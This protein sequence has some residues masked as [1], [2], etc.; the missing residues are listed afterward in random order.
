VKPPQI[1]TCASFYAFGTNQTPPV[2]RADTLRTSPRNGWW[3]DGRTASSGRE[4]DRH[5]A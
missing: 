2:E 1:A 4:V 5:C 3:C